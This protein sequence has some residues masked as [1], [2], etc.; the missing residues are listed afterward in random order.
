MQLQIQVFLSGKGI[1]ENSVYQS[2]VIVIS[3]NDDQ[4][5]ICTTKKAKGCKVHLGL[6]KTNGEELKESTDVE[7]K[8]VYEAIEFRR[9]R[10]TAKLKICT[11]GSRFPWTQIIGKILRN[12]NLRS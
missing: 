5:L 4:L 6:I 9:R 11:S 8:A 2:P 1:Q 10:K 12:V 7:S 3:I